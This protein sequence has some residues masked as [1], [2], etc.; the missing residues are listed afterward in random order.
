MGM[1]QRPRSLGGLTPLEDPWPH[2][3]LSPTRATS[4]TVPAT[5]ISPH[6]EL[7]SAPEFSTSY[8][9]S[10]SLASPPATTDPGTYRGWADL[11][12]ARLLGDGP[13]FRDV[14]KRVSELGPA[15][16]EHRALRRR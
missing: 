6:L 8:A 4:T 5:P 16:L 11:A 7:P 12:N 15:R 13:D 1:G 9:S 3:I 10:S 2:I 14:A